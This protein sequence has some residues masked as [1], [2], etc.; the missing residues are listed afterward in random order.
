MIER[1]LGDKRLKFDFPA[2]RQGADFRKE[3]H[4]YVVTCGVISS[5][6]VS[7]KPIWKSN[8]ASAFDCLNCHP[9]QSTRNHSPLK[10]AATVP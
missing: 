8:Q 3:T 4:E 2:L 6:L 10:H 9:A 5:Y 1:F 7:I